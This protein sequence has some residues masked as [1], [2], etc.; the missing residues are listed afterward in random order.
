M[1][2]FKCAVKPNLYYYFS[3]KKA[4]YKTYME[5]EK[6]QNIQIIWKTAISDESNL[7]LTL[8]ISKQ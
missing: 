4:S 5:M 7:Q 8:V 2:D 3:L 6:V 1:C